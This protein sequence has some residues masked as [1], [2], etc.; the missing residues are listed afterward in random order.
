MKSTIIIRSLA[1]LTLMAGLGV[2]SASA[3]DTAKK[4]NAEL[5]AQAQVSKQD[6]QK[7][8][9]T[10]APMGTVKEGEIE[11][12]KGLLIWSFGI[13]TPNTK[14]ITEVAVNAKT[15]KIVSAAIEKVK[16]EAKEAK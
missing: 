3:A 2:F 5:L 15:G 16:D 4:D 10:K 14:D 7:T 12:E 6:A 9:L 1:V 8:A 11:M 13:S